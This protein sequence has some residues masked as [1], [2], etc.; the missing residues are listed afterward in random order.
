MGEPMFSGDSKE[1]AICTHLRNEYRLLYKK[2]FNGTD[3]EILQVWVGAMK[4]DTF[5]SAIKY[6]VREMDERNNNY[7]SYLLLLNTSIQP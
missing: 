1:K 7:K 3:M 6:A 4:Q 2:D 5:M